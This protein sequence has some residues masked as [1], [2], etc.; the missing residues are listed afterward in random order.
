[1]LKGREEYVCDIE[2]DGLNPTKIHCVG[3]HN[4]DTKGDKTL[5]NYDDMRTFFSQEGVV[6]IIHNGLGYDKPAI[7]RILG[8]KF[9]SPVIDTL[10]LSWYLYP[11]RKLH[12]LESWGED[13]GVP[14]PEIDDWENLS[15]EE[16]CHRVE[17]DVKI[18]TQ[19]WIKIKKDLAKLYTDDVGWIKAIEYIN[20]KMKCLA[21]QAKCKWKL[22]VPAAEKL[23]EEFTTKIDLAKTG[24]QAVMPK[25]PKYAIKTRPKKPY[26]KNG[27]LSATGLKWKAL[28]DEHNLSF[29]YQGEIK[30]ISSYEEP[31]AGSVHQIKEWA[32]SLGWV[33]D[34]FDFK[35]NKETGEVKKIPQ[36]KDKDSGEIS[37]S[38]KI[39]AKKHPEFELLNELGILVH[40]KALVEGFLKN[41]DEDGFVI[42]GAAGFTNTLRLRHKV[43]LNI[44]STRKPYGKEIRGLLMARSDDFVLLGSDMASLEDRTKQH[45]MWPHD[46]EYV[47]E[48]QKPDF[49]PH[50]DIA[51]EAG[52]MTK[53]E[54]KA[55]KKMDAEELKEFE[56]PIT[57]TMY[58]KSNL[59]LKRHAGKS[60]N[61]SS[62]YGAGAA[63]IA[64]AA[65][66]P[67]SEGAKLH[68]A[69]WE[70]NWSLKAI[71]ESCKVKTCF[72]VK[73]LWNPVAQM[74]YY[75][76][77]DKDRFSTLNQ[78]TGAFCFDMWLK[79][80]LKECPKLTAQFHDEVII[81]IRR[82]SEKRAEKL[83]HD[84]VERVN[85]QLKLNRDLG[86]D[87][88]FGQNYSE[89]H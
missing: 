8:I 77:A 65:G 38:L 37:D 81:E 64:R 53:D 48:M 28:T 88:Q 45:Y 36:L 51:L 82:G 68:K 11:T 9:R 27:D 52:I 87:V 66:V 22:D 3:W 67:E 61:Y 49:D 41:C 12:G 35:R 47:K 20:F 78:G 72:K 76:K 31:N 16:Y 18:N 10:G 54:V 33:P 5:T 42:A 70:R 46:P 84:C 80:I 57:R 4:V 89:I 63:T 73:W 83:L 43:C 60:T 56:D 17:E 2:T 50:C 44:P 69:Y 29:D 85:Q 86:V 13:F 55:Y 6:F 23:V 1:M 30:V 39:L 58:K 59:S 26:K 79:E 62:T 74:W 25:V 24:L 75:L 32:F 21:L 19:L 34:K 15:L 40:R 7:E 71:A 14:K